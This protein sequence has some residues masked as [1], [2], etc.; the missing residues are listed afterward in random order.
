MM[1]ACSGN[2]F[3]GT[4]YFALHNLN[5]SL[6]YEWVFQWSVRSSSLL[7]E[8]SYVM[9]ASHCKACMHAWLVASCSR[10]R[11]RALAECA[12]SCRGILVST[13]AE[14]PPHR[15]IMSTLRF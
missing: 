1:G 8:C 14:W 10:L 2:P 11:H 15:S 12:A 13:A 4:R 7:S 6:F 9:P 5:P 3:I